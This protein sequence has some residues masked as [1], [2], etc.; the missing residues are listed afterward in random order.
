LATRDSRQRERIREVLDR[1]QKKLPSFGPVTESSVDLYPIHPH[2]FNALFQLRSA[3]PGFSPLRFLQEEIP[4]VLARPEEQ[5]VTPDCLF[6]YITPRLRGLERFSHLLAAYESFR[7][8]VLPRFKSI[9][10][11][12]VESLLKAIAFATV[13]DA[14]PVD[15]KTLA[16]SLLLYEDS[17]Y[18]P[19]YSSASSLLMEMEQKG[20]IYLIA[21]GEKL[22]R[23]YRL[24]D[25]INPP[26]LTATR[27]RLEGAEEFRRRL[28]LL[29]Y[30]WI[31]SEIPSWKPDLSSKYERSSQSLVV[32]LPEGETRPVGLVCFKSEHDPFW[33]QEDFQVLEESQYSW[34]LLVL[35]PLERAFESNAALREF[36][37]C[38]KRILIW[39]PDRPTLHEVGR[40]QELVS[41][42][43]ALGPAS[44]FET[45]A[46]AREQTRR[47]LRAMYVERGQFITAED[48]WFIGG[49]IESHRVS[50]HLS[51]HLSA[52]AVPASEPAAVESSRSRPEQ[53]TASADEKEAL[54]IAA[55]LT[56]MQE[57]QSREVVRDRMLEWWNAVLE[58]EAAVLSPKARS[59]PDSL[60]TTNFWREVKPTRNRL[61]MVKP[62]MESLRSGEASLAAAVGEILGAFGG[63]EGQ[64]LEWRDALRNLAGLIRWLPGYEHTKDYLV[65]AFP[66][67]HD[68]LDGQ[69]ACLLGLI[70][71]PHRFI[72][73]SAREK[74]D[75]EFLE[76]KKGY[77]DCYQSA[78]EEALN[79]VS[80]SK[81]AE[82]KV[83][84]KALQNLELLSNLL[85]TDKSYLNRVRILGKWILH[86]QCLLPVREILERYPR[87]YCNFNPAGN[88][89]L[90]ESAAQINTLIQEGIEYFRDAL[91]KCSLMIIEDLKILKV[92]EFHTKQIAAVL[93]HGPLTSLKPR[94]VEIINKIIEKHSS[95]FLIAL[96]G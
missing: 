43:P 63:N 93:S 65:G 41:H 19:R 68:I 45:S 13:S 16:D 71:E 73:P 72:Q 12:K 26:I 85:Y 31:H 84:A 8:T 57:L 5:L 50:R 17:D 51:V 34:L 78:H 53:A 88:R 47:I 15:V 44:A 90:A 54:R 20:G 23:S 95:D 49:E 11:D 48:Q 70:A 96:R 7:T 58:T 38:S 2:V 1:L 36:A 81:E 62:V 56:G 46:V 9:V 30:D 25:L 86:N 18:L 21:E 89:E 66:L 83:D 55:T 59:L 22:K 10:R 14:G 33:S 37:A 76:F 27:E 94:T 42:H 6:D 4:L 79:I 40:L 29:L 64:L 67:G 69:R 92:D 82:R 39:R 24:L 52:L 77:I 91:R 60:M 75:L 28:P 74:Y 32:Q 3:L 80:A 61:Q 87:C 35:S